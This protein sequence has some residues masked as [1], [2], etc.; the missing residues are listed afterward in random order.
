MTRR[1][2]SPPAVLFDEREPAAGLLTAKSRIT[3]CLWRKEWPL[4]YQA[5]LG[6]IREWARKARGRFDPKCA[7]LAMALLILAHGKPKR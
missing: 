4:P 6:S 2:P 3:A 1:D 7:K 5:W